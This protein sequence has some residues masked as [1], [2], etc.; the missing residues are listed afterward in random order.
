L[1]SQ[2][3][4]KRIAYA[5]LACA[6]AAT[7]A[8]AQVRLQPSRPTRDHAPLVASV[9]SAQIAGLGFDALL[10]DFYW[11]RAIQVVGDGAPVSDQAELVARLSETVVGLDPWVG[12]PYRFA[13]LWISEH[14]ATVQTANRILE[15]GI[16]YHPDDWRNRF[17]LSFNHF[18]ELGDMEAAA[19]ELE[20]AISLPRAPRYLGRL[21]ARLRSEHGDIE[22]A[23]T[24]LQ[25]L[26]ENT[27]DEW[28]RVE[29]E[30]ALDEI[31]AERRAR[32]LDA[33]R[34]T[35]RTRTGRDIER[36][37]ELAEGSNAVLGRL[38][39]SP[40]AWG[41]S[42]DPNTREIVSNYY[43][44]RYKLNFQ[45]DVGVLADPTKGPR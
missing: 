8:A 42:L 45:R 32:F 1:A 14:P 41:W 22:T 21:L 44:R 3:V 7:T 13:T 25:G 23:A 40:Q 10:A 16:A 18:F 15:R 5:V 9:S 31:D 33:A 26:L 36:V 38:P 28:Q 20:P 37:E 39:D 19:R 35:F 24:F 4:R 29:Y 30:K 12:H 6:T 11:L 17:H 43:G 34:E 2:Q 27:T